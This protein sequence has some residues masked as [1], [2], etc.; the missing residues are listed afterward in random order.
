MQYNPLFMPQLLQFRPFLGALIEPEAI[1]TNR[2]WKTFISFS[3]VSLPSAKV[4]WRAISKTGQ[5]HALVNMYL[6]TP[7]SINTGNIM[8]CLLLPWDTLEDPH[9]LVR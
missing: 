6:A 4:V 8:L 2:H 9:T 5:L 1:L 7:A 3:I